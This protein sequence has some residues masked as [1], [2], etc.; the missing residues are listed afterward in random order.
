MFEDPKI[1]NFFE[2]RT[3]EHEEYFGVEEFSALQFEFD[4]AVKMLRFL[5]L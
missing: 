5:F 1:N 3:P 2:F 4:C